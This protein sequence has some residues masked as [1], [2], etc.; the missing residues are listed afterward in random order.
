MYSLIEVEFRVSLLDDLLV[1]LFEVLGQDHIAVLADCL[2][3]SLLADALDVSGG[4]LLRAGNEIFK[5]NFLT[6]VHLA[7]EGLEHQALLPAVR[8]RELDLAIETP[9]S[10]ECG[11]QG[12]C[13]VS[14]HDD[15][16][17]NG[18]IETIH[19]LQKL[20]E[21]TLDLTIR[22]SVGIETLSGNRIDF[23]NEDN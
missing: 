22:T 11:V 14:G 3:T 18:L 6:Q 4:D 10:Q 21:D 16:N 7:S 1:S 23:I 20:N 17:I 15:L 13:T 5:V 2:H 8:K 12:V 9:G 19:L